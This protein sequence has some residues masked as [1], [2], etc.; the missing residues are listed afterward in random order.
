M[1]SGIMTVFGFIL[2]LLFLIFQVTCQN[3][4]NL[5]FADLIINISFLDEIMSGRC[6]LNMENNQ[7]VIGKG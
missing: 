7:E 4:K 6:E 2:P 1:P 5:I 3:S